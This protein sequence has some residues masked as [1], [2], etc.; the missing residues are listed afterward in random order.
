MRITDSKRRRA[1]PPF[2][3]RVHAR[4]RRHPLAERAFRYRQLM[5]RPLSRYSARR[6]VRMRQISL[7]HLDSQGYNH[8]RLPFQLGPDCRHRGSVTESRSWAKV[9]EIRRRIV[10][11]ISVNVVKCKLEYL[12]I[13]DRW[14]RM[15]LANGVIAPNRHSFITSPCFVEAS[16]CASRMGFGTQA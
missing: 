15:K 2:R 3:V 12:V 9:T 4:V 10:E 11:S 1:A 6:H 8:L 5:L 7:S 16:N 14:A 13:P